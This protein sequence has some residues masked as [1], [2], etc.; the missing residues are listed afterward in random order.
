MT[1]RTSSVAE[2]LAE[3]LATI[4]SQAVE[5]GYSSTEADV[6]ITD[7]AGLDAERAA[8]CWLFRLALVRDGRDP[9]TVDQQVG[10][11]IARFR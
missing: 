9:A 11:F 7:L 6:L 3:T 10:H 5:S 8:E 1:R 2:V 4:R